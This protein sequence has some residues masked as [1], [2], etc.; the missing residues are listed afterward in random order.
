MD[1]QP[2][3]HLYMHMR[4]NLGMHLHHAWLLYMPSELGTP[5]TMIGALLGCWYGQVL[6]IMVLCE[7]PSCITFTFKC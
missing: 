6:M 7:V 4:L 1:Q 5:G 3:A 2:M